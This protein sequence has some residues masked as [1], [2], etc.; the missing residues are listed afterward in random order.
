MDNIL[1]K[2]GAVIVLFIITGTILL[3][4]MKNVGGM[5]TWLNDNYMPRKIMILENYPVRIIM[6]GEFDEDKND[7]KTASRIIQIISAMDNVKHAEGK[8]DWNLRLDFMHNLNTKQIRSSQ[9]AIGAK[10][11]DA[12]IH[13]W[14]NDGKK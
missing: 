1:T 7:T 4:V 14:D 12:D 11:Q 8:F 10:I 13:T 5:S 3:S 2:W 6:L 9:R